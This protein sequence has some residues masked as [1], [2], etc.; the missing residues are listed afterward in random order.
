MLIVLVGTLGY[1][2]IE[3]WGLLDSLYMTI[4]SLTTVGYSEVAP[5]SSEGKIFTIALLV[6]GVGVAA[7]AIGTGFRIIVEGEIQLLRG[8]LRM[9]KKIDSLEGHHIVCGYG[10]LG[11]IV[12]REFAELGEKVLVLDKDP[13]RAEELERIGVPYIVGNAY[14]DEILKSAR[15]DTARTLLTL[16][17]SDADNVYVTLCAR[18]LNPNISIV[19]RT[20]HEEGE[21]RLRRAGANNVIAPYRVSGNRLVQRVLRPHVSEF[22]ELATSPKG[23]QLVIEEIQVPSNSALAGCSLQETDLRN[24]TGAVI[25]AAIDSDGTMTYN[26]GG[27]SLIKA[28]STLVALGERGALEELSKIIAEE[29][30]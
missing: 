26:P 30:K 8:T 10:R 4:I 1:H 24:R 11:S 5:M 20:D 7:Y 3:G 12:V 14:E 17:S 19:A 22:L 25:A 21:R 23:M 18:D 29:A 16:L 27:S 15:I 13:G 28:G 2:F 9:Q 6:I